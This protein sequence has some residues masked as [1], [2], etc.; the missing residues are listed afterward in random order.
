MMSPP[1]IF[2]TVVSE[3]GCSCDR[4]VLNYVCCVLEKL[5]MSKSLTQK[6][7]RAAAVAALATVAD[8]STAIYV[9]VGSLQQ[10]S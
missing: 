3:P 7:K 5:L 8:G 1:K 6:R 4:L 9:Q 10:Q 2:P